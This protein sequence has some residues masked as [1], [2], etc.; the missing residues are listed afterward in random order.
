M[1]TLSVWGRHWSSWWG[2]A[3]GRRLLRWV[4]GLWVS[5][6]TLVGPL[7]RTIFCR[8][9][10]WLPDARLHCDQRPR[11]IWKERIS[12]THGKMNFPEWHFFVITWSHFLQPFSG[13]SRWAISPLRRCR[14]TR[15]E[16][17]IFVRNCDFFVEEHF[18]LPFGHKSYPAMMTLIP[19]ETKDV[20]G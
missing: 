11:H 19:L 14:W 5:A 15:L 13:F 20:T 17:F 10:C 3:W 1:H 7:G 16:K 9:G 12:I 8:A 2:G 4:R 6:C 18:F